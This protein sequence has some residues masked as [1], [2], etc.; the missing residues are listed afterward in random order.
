VIS[1]LHKLNQIDR[2][3]IVA[4]LTLNFVGV[5]CMRNEFLSRDVESL[6]NELI[7]ETP[8]GLTLLD[9]EKILKNR[10][11][12]PIVSS[13]AG[14]LKQENGLSEVVGAQSIRAHLGDYRSS[15]FFI[16]SVTAFWG[17]DENG[18][19]IDIWVWKTQD[20]P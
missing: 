9:V 4:V 18:E 20:G 19:L 3:I 10:G 17:F 7:Q 11:L 5:G 2:L 6:R 14:F 12:V 1:V 15:L 16:T 13:T 8:R